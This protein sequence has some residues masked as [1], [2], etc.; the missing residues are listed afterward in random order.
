MNCHAVAASLTKRGYIV[1][2]PEHPQTIG[3]ALAD[4]PAGLAAWRAV[5]MIMLASHLLR[6]VD[7]RAEALK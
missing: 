6:I 7:A 5:E 1:E 4:T 2:M 3:Y